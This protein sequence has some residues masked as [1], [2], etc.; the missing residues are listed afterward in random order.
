MCKHKYLQN[1][2]K[3]PTLSYNDWFDWAD[4]QLEKGNYQKLCSCCNRYVWVGK[5]KEK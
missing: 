1:Q 3:E 5:S 4:K 2:I